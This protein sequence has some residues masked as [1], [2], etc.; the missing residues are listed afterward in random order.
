MAESYPNRKK[1]LWE[2][3]KS[4]VMSNFS[5]SHGVFKGYVMQTPKNKGLFWERGKLGL[6]VNCQK[7][8]KTVLGKC[9]NAGCQLFRLIPKCFQMLSFF[10]SVF[11]N[12]VLCCKGF[13]Y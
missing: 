3:E 11:N 1:T 8:R 12:M 9:E 4:L 5:F 10:S 13:M 7:E 2:K 6:V